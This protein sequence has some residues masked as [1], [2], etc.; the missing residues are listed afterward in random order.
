M[1]EISSAPACT[2]HLIAR[3]RTHARAQEEHEEGPQRQQLLLQHHPPPDAPA[4]T[5]SISSS[6]AMLAAVSQQA[7]LGVWA[8][9]PGADSA[10]SLRRRSL[11]R[12][13]LADV[14]HHVARL[15]SKSDRPCNMEAAAASD[16]PGVVKLLWLC[17]NQLV[18][19]LHSVLPSSR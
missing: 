16:K 13:P 6:A 18:P 17:D 4:R 19:H 3:A 7:P 15:G 9:A 14:L 11:A 5:S 1:Y 12:A 10:R 2:L 8:S